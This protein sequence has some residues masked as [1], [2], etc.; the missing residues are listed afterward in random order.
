[1]NR[2]A[3]LAGTAIAGLG[4]ANGLDAKAFD[5]ER[6]LDRESIVKRHNPR[7]IAPNLMSPMQ[8]GN[9]QLGFGADIT[10]LQTFPEEYSKQ[11]ALSTLSE[12][13]WHSFPN[14]EH[15]QLSED[16]KLFNSHGRQVPYLDAVGDMFPSQAPPRVH[17]AAKWLIA[18]PHRILLARIGLILPNGKRLELHSIRQIDETLDLWTGVLVSKFELSGEMVEVTTVCHSDQGSLGVRIRSRLLDG[19][20]LGLSIAS[21]MLLADGIFPAIGPRQRRINMKHCWRSMRSTL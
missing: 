18:N 11:S 5:K 10:G 2:R 9:G 14:P 1:M 19:Q 13:G 7:L 3:F 16:W 12:W 8:L 20:R 17:A 6:V 15:Y 21:R 4:L